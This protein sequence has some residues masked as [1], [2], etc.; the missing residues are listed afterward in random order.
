MQCRCA[1]HSDLDFHT[2]RA[3]K[4]KPDGFIPVAID[5]VI[6]TEGARIAFD[7]LN[8]LLGF[9][10]RDAPEFLSF[11]HAKHAFG[12]RYQAADLLDHSPA[13]PFGL[14]PFCTVGGFSRLTCLVCQNARCVDKR[15]YSFLRRTVFN[16]P[17]GMRVVANPLGG[18]PA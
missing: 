18:R 17:Y 9:D 16:M 14:T 15:F 10:E 7:K 2:L 13:L 3:R 12:N 6:A 5:H 1:R 11:T 8:A 4:P